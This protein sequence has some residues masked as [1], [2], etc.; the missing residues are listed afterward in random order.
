MVMENPALL[1]VFE[2]FGMENAFQGKTVAQACHACQI[3]ERLFLLVANLVNGYPPATLPELNPSEISSVIAFLKN[4]HAYYRTE[5]YPEI[6]ALI[7]EMIARNP[8]G[9]I[10]LIGGFFEEYYREVCEHLDYEDQVAFPYFFALTGGYDFEA[11][12]YCSAEYRDHHTDIETK[13]T[14]LKHLLLLHIPV[15]RDIDI[16]R[17]LLVS[18]FAFEHYMQIHRQ[19]EEEILIPQ[20]E[21][22]ENENRL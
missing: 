1:L 22:L 15:S 4:A 11:M 6:R 16:R 10:R 17:K 8:S 13:L 21:R 19:I 14:D 18:L 9:P 20:I 5:K 3:S 2:H 7:E 12:P